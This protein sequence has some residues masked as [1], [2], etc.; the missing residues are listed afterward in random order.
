[1]HRCEATKFKI[2]TQYELEDNI[3]DS[4]QSMQVLAIGITSQSDR[5]VILK[6]KPTRY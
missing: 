6:Q 4:L 2:E 1:M 3:F 5:I